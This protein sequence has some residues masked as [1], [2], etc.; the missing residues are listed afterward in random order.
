MSGARQANGVRQ[1]LADRQLSRPVDP[2]DDVQARESRGTTFV[3]G[4][5][6]SIRSIR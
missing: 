1:R 3:R 6:R 4:V 5:S 2:V